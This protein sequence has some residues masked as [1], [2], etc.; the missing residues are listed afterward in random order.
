M[1][2]IFKKNIKHTQKIVALVLIVTLYFMPFEI[3]AEPEKPTNVSPANGST[4]VSLTPTLESSSY[5]NIIPVESDI[6]ALIP[7][8]WIDFSDASTVTTVSGKVSQVTD[9]S[10]NGRTFTQNTGVKRPIYQSAVQNSLNVA[11]FDGVEEVLQLSSNTMFRNIGGASLY[12]ILKPESG[13]ATGDVY[14]SSGNGLSTNRI[15]LLY[16]HNLFK[17][18]MA[19]RR[20]DSDSF[21][22]VIQTGTTSPGSFMMISN[23]YDWSNAS[24]FT[25]KDRNLIGTSTSFHTAGNTS[26]T[27]AN[28]TRIGA[29]LSE[30]DFWFGDIGEIIV[31]NSVHDADT[32]DTVEQYLNNKWAIFAEE[33]HLASQWQ[34]TDT[35]GDYSSPVYDSG[36]DAANLESITIPSSTLSGLTTY[37]WRVKY[38]DEDNVW[39]DWSDETSFTTETD[40]VGSLSVDIVDAGGTTVGSPSAQMDSQTFSFSDQTSTGTFGTSSQKIRVDNGTGTATWTLSLAADIGATAIWD[41]T[42]ADYDFNDPTASAADGGDTDSLGGQMTIN[43]TTITITP[44]GGCTTTNVSGGSS[45][46]FSEGVTDSI[47]LASASSGADTDCYWDLTDI[48]ISQT[49]PAEQPADDYAI[50][51]TLSIIAS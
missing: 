32:K 45:S 26:N 42:S 40:V 29:N 49:I 19:G 46:A 36:E 39:S 4:D 23:V 18:S 20:L 7:N 50:D 41:G 28:L 12:I 2:N 38:K 48:S 15:Y 1:L 27:N 30:N 11:R 37:Y 21:Q 43:P 17:F 9:K 16:S 22:N 6:S 3:F 24:I 8:M 35:S 10:G 25:Y 44:E 47:T 5:E 13:G 34:V 31:F 14:F 33:T 51:M